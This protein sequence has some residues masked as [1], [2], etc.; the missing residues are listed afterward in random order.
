M[1]GITRGGRWELLKTGWRIPCRKVSYPWVGPSHIRADPFAGKIRLI[2]SASGAR[3][4]LQLPP[5]ASNGPVVDI[6]VTNTAIA[7][8]GA[9]HSVTVF[10]VPSSWDSDDPSCET[11]VHI[12]PSEKR[13]SPQ[14]TLGEV[15]K[16]EWQNDGGRLAVGG[17]EGVVIISPADEA[18]QSPSA[19]V[20]GF[21]RRTSMDVIGRANKVLKTDGVS[22]SR[23]RLDLAN[24]AQTLTSFCF[25]YPRMAIALLSST[26]VLSLFSVDTLKRA[27]HRQLPTSDP[28][29]IPSSVNFCEA[30]IL[31]GRDN[32]TLYDLVQ[33]TKDLALF[34]S[35]RFTSPS[36]SP[37]ELN[38]TQ[39]VYDA[40]KE[41]LWIGAFSRGSLYGFRYVLKGLPPIEGAPEG[42]VR[43]F[44]AMVEYPLEPVLS[45]VLAEG[46][47]DGD[48]ELFFAHPTGF[49][50]GQID[51]ASVRRLREFI[52]ETPR[53][54][55]PT[56]DPVPTDATPTVLPPAAP[57]SAKK[58]RGAAGKQSKAA[59]PLAAKLDL[60]PVDQP[61]E[62]AP[63]EG[64]EFSGVS[65]EEFRTTLEKVS[66][67]GV[68]TCS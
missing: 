42:S 60:P 44:D 13:Q 25:N 33:I 46:T 37:S 31:V 5:T 6:A 12:S 38:F 41:I 24:R 64:K 20:P 27:W 29:S 14:E 54:M 47:A 53:E 34:S 49:S 40:K 1:S 39:P 45:M 51:K 8:I 32:N 66:D 50:Q 52:S 21:E 36:P 28:T 58:V 26:S 57:A 62:P 19:G 56:P 23:R 67:Q 55:S 17:T 4:V 68:T 65:A 30:N 43:A 10:S 3:L 7:A 48:T 16:V 63:V 59:S 9:D 22:Q 11:I 35:I 2:D 15:F 61:D 18:E